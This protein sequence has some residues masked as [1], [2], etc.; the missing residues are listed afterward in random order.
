MLIWTEPAVDPRLTTV[1]LAEAP[2]YAVVSEDHLMAQKESLKLKDLS[3]SGGLFWI[4]ESIQRST[5]R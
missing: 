5:N 3:A 4:E 1:K 2:L